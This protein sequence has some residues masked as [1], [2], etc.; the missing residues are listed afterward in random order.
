LAYQRKYRAENGRGE[1]KDNFGRDRCTQ[2]Y[3][4]SLIQKP[5]KKPNENRTN[6]AEIVGITL[7]HERTGEYH[8]FPDLTKMVKF[9]HKYRKSVAISAA[10]DWQFIAIQKGLDAISI[11][12]EPIFRRTR[13]NAFD[14]I[15]TGETH[16]VTGCAIMTTPKICFSNALMYFSD[17]VFR[18]G[19]KKENMLFTYTGRA[20]KVPADEIP[21]ILKRECDFTKTTVDWIANQTDYESKKLFKFGRFRTAGMVIMQQ[22]KPKEYDM[23]RL[24]WQNYKKGEGQLAIPFRNYA[25]SAFLQQFNFI[26]VG[27]QDRVLENIVQIDV[28]SMYPSI[29]MSLP[30]PYGQHCHWY[31]RKSAEEQ[32]TDV[33]EGYRNQSLFFTIVEVEADRIKL[34]SGGLPTAVAKTF[35]QNDD[36][37]MQLAS[38]ILPEGGKHFG[39]LIDSKSNWGRSNLDKTFRQAMPYTD[40]LH[41]KKNYHCENLRLNSFCVYRVCTGMYNEYLER[42]LSM[43]MTAEAEGNWIGA[44]CCKYYANLVYGKHAERGKGRYVPFSAAVAA[45]AR[46]YLFDTIYKIGVEN[47]VYADTDSIHFLDPNGSILQNLVKTGR[48]GDDFGLFKVEEQNVRGKYIGLKAYV[49]EK[50]GEKEYT[51][52]GYSE[53]DESEKFLRKLP[54]E[55]FGRD[56]VIPKGVIGWREVEHGI[57][58]EYRPYRFRKSGLALA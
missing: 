46:H 58:P 19:K 3:Y 17:G 36:G 39:Y 7:L 41:L 9:L 40:F 6:D 25:Q 18:K 52:A 14:Q 51:I 35:V 54:I 37:S 10:L 13:G 47:F 11:K 43:R 2:Y 21:E 57:L 29:M 22:S 15:I 4:M 30:L 16:Q 42:L 5:I 24:Y 55:E 27:K 48:V 38:F 49:Q 56:I 26:G 32:F 44:D 33:P 50:N 12:A 31:K 28:N 23:Q 45:A 1:R 20:W 53:S 34:K 8:H